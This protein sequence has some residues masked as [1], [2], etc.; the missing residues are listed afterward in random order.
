[1][2]KILMKLY[3]AGLLAKLAKCQFEVPRI[4]FLGYVVGKEG[5]S[6]D[7]KKTQAVKDWNPLEMVKQL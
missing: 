4:E 7:S 1:M 2:Q 3:R 6:T 5:V